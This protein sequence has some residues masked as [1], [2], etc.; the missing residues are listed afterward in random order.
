MEKILKI[1]F[2]SII[3][4][5]FLRIVLLCFTTQSHAIPL[6]SQ[7]LPAHN[8]C[9][10]HLG[11]VEEQY[12]IPNTLLHSIAKVESGRA[13]GGGQITP[14]PWA[15]NVEGQGYYYSTKEEAIRAV[16]KRQAQGVKNI[17]VGCMQINLHHH[18]HAFPNLAA[19]FDP[20]RNIEYAAKLLTGLKQG[21][22]SWAKAVGNYH[23]A[24]PHL[25]K[26]YRNKVLALWIQNYKNGQYFEKP[27]QTLLGKRLHRLKRLEKEPEVYAAASQPHST[28][29]R[30]VGRIR[31]PARLHTISYGGSSSKSIRRT[32]KR[33]LIAR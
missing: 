29:I 28:P 23:S 24:T 2:A 19:A 10:N 30:K 15:I 27:R 16:E 3:W 4:V 22:F 18:G 9:L 25:H 31:S 32:S 11:K 6:P 5:L 1:T 33:H 13:S 8:A 17:D 7:Q 12:K 20:V 21:A 14:W 26:N